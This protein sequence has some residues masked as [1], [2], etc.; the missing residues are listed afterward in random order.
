MQSLFVVPCDA[1]GTAGATQ[2]CS[3]CKCVYYC[4]RTC[5]QEDWKYHKATCAALMPRINEFKRLDE[6]MDRLA[7]G[8]DRIESEECAIC[9]GHLNTP[10]LLRCGHAFCIRCLELHNM[11][12]GTTCPMCRAQLDDNLVQYIYTNA[13]YFLQSLQRRK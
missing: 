9:L 5:Q 2:K 4:N 7:A 12:G 8:Y 3:Q 1:C 6:S 10:T 13:S 11:S